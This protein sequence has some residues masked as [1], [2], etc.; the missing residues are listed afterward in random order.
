MPDPTI[1]PEMARA[2]LARRELAR[3]QEQP[4]VDT[5]MNFFVPGAGALRSMVSEAVGEGPVDTF[6]QGASLNAIDEA[7]AASR[8]TALTR[9]GNALFQSLPFV[10][11]YS[12]PQDYDRAWQSFNEVYEP[13][14]RDE[15]KDYIAFKQS[16]PK[17]SMLLE[18]AGAVVPAMMLQS[19]VLPELGADALTTSQALKAIPKATLANAGQGAVSGI[20]S[21]DG[22]ADRLNRGVMAAGMA[23]L[24]TPAFGVPAAYAAPYVQ[25]IAKA[26]SGPISGGSERGS[27]SGNPIITEPTPTVPQLNPAQTMLAKQVRTVPDDEIQKG[28]ETVNKYWDSG[29]PVTFGEA[30]PAYNLAG[31]TRALANNDETAFLLRQGYE[32]RDKDQ[33]ARMYG[34]LDDVVKGG[35]KH[36]DAQALQDAAREV[37]KS[38]ESALDV[39]SGLAY[40]EAGAV[41][42]YLDPSV[43]G[44]IADVLGNKEAAAAYNYLRNHDRYRDLP[45]FSTTLV[46]RTKSLLKDELDSMLAAGSKNKGEIV[47]NDFNRLREGV[48]TGNPTWASADDFYRSEAEAIQ[49]LKDSP[50]GM[51]ANPQANALEA[52]KRL[53]KMSVPQIEAVKDALGVERAD[54][55]AK[56]IRAAFQDRIENTKSG[57]Q[58]LPEVFRTPE[59]RARLEAM[60]G[61]PYSDKLLT[62]LEGE[63]AIQKNTSRVTGN[64]A[65]SDTLL[66]NKDLDASASNI[67]KIAASAKGKGVLGNLADALE[68]VMRTDAKEQVKRDYGKLISSMGQRGPQ[69]LNNTEMIDSLADILRYRA[70][71]RPQWE[72]Q[73]AGARVG[74]GASGV[75]GQRYGKYLGSDDD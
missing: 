15:T 18:T 38:R 67:A 68:Y 28:I 22:A 11:T 60:I 66:A 74:R 50:V 56:G 69:G 29:V 3:R 34:Y 43:R 64:S 46:H 37:I 65:T 49:G 14:K 70:Y 26:L 55:L 23:S 13:N 16:N 48:R 72:T 62:R 63:L 31:K 58:Q 12:N 75:V 8:P 19:A 21:G 30:N 33:L 35:N 36:E 61:K 51:L 1:T 47:L 41:E 32:S 4:L 2:E 71:W 53:S 57:F 45:E 52:A 27:F 44:K 17:T 20:M 24:A 9:L 54:A 39:A 5:A 6:E 7:R 40:D 59:G 42:P 10:S 25:R 73:Q